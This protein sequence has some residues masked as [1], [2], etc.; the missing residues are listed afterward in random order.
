MTLY[1]FLIN[2]TTYALTLFSQTKPPKVKDAPMGPPVWLDVNMEAGTVLTHVS[3]PTI[4]T[5]ALSAIAWG[6]TGLSEAER[7]IFNHYIIC[8]DTHEDL[9][10]GQ[11]SELGNKTSY[12]V[13]DV[14]FYFYQHS[15]HLHSFRECS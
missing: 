14:L 2:D 5:I 4:H 7:V 11:V 10:F 9:R 8:N 1:I 12:S 6:Q 15:G 3:Q 13:L